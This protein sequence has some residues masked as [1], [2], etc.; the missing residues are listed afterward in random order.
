MR[1]A[2]SGRKERF[3]LAL[4]L[5][6]TLLVA[7]VPQAFA[8]FGGGGGRGGGFGGGGGRSFGGGGF[9]GGGGRS[10]GGDGFGGGSFGHSSSGGGSQSHGGYGS[11]GSQYHPSSSSENESNASS[12]HQN[13]QQS[14]YNEYNTNQQTKYNEANTLQTNQEDTEKSMH[15]STMNTVNNSYNYQNG[16]SYGCCYDDDSSSTGEALGAAALG[17]VGGVAVGSMMTANAQAKAPTTTVVENYPPYGYQPVP[18]GPPAMGSTVYSLPPGA[19]ETTV[20]GST[21]YMA[22]GVY[23][24]P[25]YSGSQVVYMV[26]QP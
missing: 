1:S 14:R 3:S 21:Y 13:N 7:S 18:S 9:G 25:F 8:R 20:N 22:N 10:F 2:N 24:K 11:S 23:Y 16:G 19:Y 5:V 17:A 6:T 4:I 26:S 12:A 15:N